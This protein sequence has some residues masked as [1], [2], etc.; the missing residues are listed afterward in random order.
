MP[1]EIHDE[2][3][4]LPSSH[5]YLEDFVY[6]GI[7]GSVTTFA[8]V[9]GV[10]G[11]ALAS[12][13][14]VILGLANLLADGFAMGVGNYLSGRAKDQQY[15]RAE[16]RE[17]WEMDNLPDKEK[18]EIREIYRDK[19]FDGQLLEDVVEKITSRR[20]VWLKTMMVDELGMMR[21]GK[22]PIWAAVMT[23]V[24]FNV[25][26]IIPLI[27]YIVGISFPDKFSTFF[28]ASIIMTGV[29]LGVVGWVKGNMVGRS[30]LRSSVETILIGGVAASVS[31]AVGYFLK[32]LAA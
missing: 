6:G 21:E 9:A 25:V 24:S 20:D 12:V 27:P 19:G 30:R 1:I 31:Y 11:A 32:S 13:I 23:F 28:P 17:I 5:K 3:S 10:Q 29:A 22:S 4:H 2:S 14:V 8:V 26:G 18:E 7:D 15:D 16:E